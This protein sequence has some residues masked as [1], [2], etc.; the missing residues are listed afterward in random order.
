MA[1]SN[2]IILNS[3]SLFVSRYFNEDIYKNVL[4]KMF[5]VLQPDHVQLLHGYLITLIN[6]M[7]L[8]FFY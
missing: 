5:P 3:P 1:T 4:T 2:P 7:I 6:V 8:L